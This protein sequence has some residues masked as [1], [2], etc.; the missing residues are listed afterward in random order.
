MNYMICLK[1]YL[2]YE[3][4][5][6]AGIAAEKL[7]KQKSREKQG[8]AGKSRKAEAKKQRGRSK[9][10]E[11]QKS[12]EAEAKNYISREAGKSR[13]AKSREAEKQRSRT[14]NG[15]KNALLLYIL[16]LF[17]YLYVYSHVCVYLHNNHNMEVS[18]NRA[19]V[20]QNR[21]I[22]V[23]CY[24][25]NHPAI[26]GTTIFYWNSELQTCFDADLGVFVIFVGSLNGFLKD[27]VYTLHVDNMW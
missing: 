9:E 8:K 5:K 23:G 7:E 11:K 19:T 20:P 22:L 1:D 3:K 25:I 4:Q 26:G 12:G 10:A 14:Q 15:K 2:Q 6:K 13:I 24:F 18:W 16:D 27:D 17:Y 21:P